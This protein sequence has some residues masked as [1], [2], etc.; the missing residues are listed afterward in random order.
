[1]SSPCPFSIDP[2]VGD[3]DGETARLRAEGPLT[4]IDLLGVPA[5]TVTDH[6]IA[7]Q[8]TTDA[9]LVKDI[10][11]WALYADGVVTNQWP[12][13]GMV[14]AGRSMF[15]V[16]GAEHRRLRLKTAQA[17]APRRLEELR[18]VIE[19]LTA[20]LLDDLAAAGADGAPVDLK[21]VFAYPLPMRVVGDLMGVARE[22]HAQLLDWYKKFFSV[23][24]PQ[25]ERLRVIGDLDV[26]FTDQ[27]R[28][29]IADPGDDLTS[30]FVV[31]DEEGG[32]ALTEEEAIGNIKALVA[33]GHETTVSLIVNTVRALL[34]EPEQL[35]KVL[36]GDVEWKQVIEE[37]LRWDG[38]VSHLLMRFATEDI[39][40][41]DT[42]IAKGEGVVMSYRAIGRDTAVH[43]ETADEFD[44]TRPT[45]H[46]HLAFGYGPHI[47]PG[48]ALS[49]LEA[50]VA[51]PALFA[52]FPGLRLAVP[53]SELGNLP[54][55]TQNDLAA[56]PIILN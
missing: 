50:A 13:I 40:V 3:L 16:D 56:L 6:A 29:K 30:A 18:P 45:A 22:D 12:L 28:R 46:R 42:V 14:D 44:V 9:R 21:Q 52:R 35:A 26:Y 54:V 51:L 37:S 1:M 34:N 7:R 36:A 19:R 53:D 15:T 31:A 41:G 5:W 20:E 24:T 17:L 48:A 49:R 25:D 38:P 10:N 27:V 39:T 43:G 23:M 2:M 33:A 4:R 32:A 47:C 8:L 55:L 11:A